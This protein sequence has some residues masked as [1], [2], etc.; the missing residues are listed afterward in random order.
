MILLKYHLK[1]LII[2]KQHNV[3]ICNQATIDCELNWKD[4]Q[5][6]FK[7]SLNVFMKLLSSSFDT[8]KL[9]TSLLL[10]FLKI[11]MKYEKKLDNHQ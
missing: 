1:Y 9:R 2:S 4:G 5:V 10:I 6:L 7:K 8:I 11:E 3:L